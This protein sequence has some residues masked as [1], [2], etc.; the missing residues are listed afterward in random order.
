M[1]YETVNLF[2]LVSFFGVEEDFFVFLLFE[3]L[4][5]VHASDADE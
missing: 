4:A 3:F 2:F 1:D 5:E